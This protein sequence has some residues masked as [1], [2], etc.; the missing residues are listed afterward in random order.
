MALF[1]ECMQQC[2]KKVVDNADIVRDGR[3]LDLY[4]QTHQPEPAR[5]LVS[6]IKALQSTDPRLSPDDLSQGWQPDQ[7]IDP[8]IMISPV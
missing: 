8:R 3:F 7:N 1:S 6:V 5:L 4:E 2:A